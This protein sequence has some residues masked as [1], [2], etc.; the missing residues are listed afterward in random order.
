MQN[1]IDGTI[2]EACNYQPYIVKLIDGSVKDILK[3]ATGL[4]SDKDVENIVSGACADLK[5]TM[6]C[7]WQ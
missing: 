7:G 5:D 1:S 3:L 2:F 6:K 4:R